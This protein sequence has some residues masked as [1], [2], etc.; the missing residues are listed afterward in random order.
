MRGGA[1]TPAGVLLQPAL[2]RGDLVVCGPVVAELVAGTPETDRARLRDLLLGLRWVELSRDDWTLVGSLAGKLR[3]RGEKLALTDIEIAVAA[4]SSNT[5]L[6]THD[7][8]FD[9][10]AAI[11]PKLKL[12]QPGRTEDP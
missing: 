6:A 8:D 2:E 4:I 9:R 10:I 12:T 3:G 11:E 1:K 7:A 5:E